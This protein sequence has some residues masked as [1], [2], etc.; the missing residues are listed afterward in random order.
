MTRPTTESPETTTRSAPLTN[1]APLDG[2]AEAVAEAFALPLAAA[3]LALE[4]TACLF[5]QAVLDP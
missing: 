5:T 4:D 3:T 2:V 1:V